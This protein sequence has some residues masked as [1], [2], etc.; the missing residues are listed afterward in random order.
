MEVI[1][2]ESNDVALDV[3]MSVSSFVLAIL[4]AELR[5]RSEM[6]DRRKGLSDKRTRT[7]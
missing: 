6:G 3:K 5:P 4:L 7:E 1:D 2:H